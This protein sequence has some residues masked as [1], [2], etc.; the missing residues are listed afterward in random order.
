MVDVSRKPVTTRVARAACRVVMR[1]ATLEQIFAG[2]LP[3]GDVL[4]VAR[5]A[6]IQAAKRTA[7]LIPLCHPLALTHVGIEFE[8]RSPDALEITAECRVLG[9]T[10]VEMEAMTAV[11]VAALTVY[12]MCKAI[13]RA[14]VIDAVRLLSKR[15]GRSRNWHAEAR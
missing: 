8:R 5:L 3:K 10:G 4:S 13:D 7:E 12:D 14:I 11:T 1:K 6:G 15:G 9:Q 2:T